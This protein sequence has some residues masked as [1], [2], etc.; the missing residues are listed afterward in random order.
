MRVLVVGSGGREHALAWGLV[1]SGDVDDV[2]CAPGNPGMERL[3]DCLPL[4]TSDPAA[5]AD[6]ADS[7]DAGL[8]VV[9]PED[10]LVAGAVDALE[11]AG[12]SRLRSCLRRCP[13]RGLQGVDEGGPRRRWRADGATQVLRGGRRSGRSR[14]SPVALGPLRRQDRRPRGGQGCRRA[15][16]PRRR[17]RRGARVPVGTGLRR[18]WAHRGDRGGAHRPGAVAARALRRARGHTAGAGAGLQ[19]GSRRRRRPQHRRD[20]RLLAGSGRGSGD[21]RRGHEQV[22]AAGPDGTHGTGRRVSRNPLRGP[23]AH[24]RRV[25]DHRVQRQVR[26]PRVPSRGAPPRERPVPPPDRV[27]AR[28]SGRRGPIRRRRVCDGRARDRWLPHVATQ[29]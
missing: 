8:V 7:V 15:A 5:I 24:P 4:D 28:P 13:P 3:G 21:H 9:G 14:L 20:G 29:G 23:D 22:R 1:R 25:E 27:C 16:L 19:A 11:C 17:A 12:P 6:L 18:R 26:R 10:P 2:V